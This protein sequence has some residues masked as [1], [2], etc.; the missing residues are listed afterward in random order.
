MRVDYV[1]VDETPLLTPAGKPAGGALLW[2]DRVRVLDES[3]SLAR[4]RT[5]RSRTPCHV[6]KA[7][8]GGRSLLEFYFID[9]GQGDGVLIRTPD[10]RH[11]LIDAGFPRAS[12]P[13]GKNA[14]DFVDWKF[15]RDYGQ[16]TIALDAVIASHNDEDHYGGLSDLVSPDPNDVAELDAAGVTVENFYH[17]GLSWWAGAERNLGPSVAT[18]QGEMWTRLLGNRASAAAALSGAGPQLQG[19]WARFIG[20]M[21]GAKTA[22]GGSTPFTRLSHDHGYLPGF[23][24]APG[25]AAIKVLAPVEFTVGGQPALRRLPAGDSQNTNGQSVLLRIDY[26]RARILL[27]GDLNAAAQGALLAD[28]A[29][30]SQELECDVAKACHHGSDDVSYRFLQAL[31]PA[32]TVISS[33]DNE[34]HDHPRP[35]IVGASA[36]TGYLE[37]QND[38]IVSP[39]IYSTELAR[40]LKLKRADSLQ[41]PLKTGETL[42]VTGKSLART[43]A[44]FDEGGTPPKV[45]RRGLDRTRLVTD[46]IYGLVNVRTDG[47][48]ILCATMGEKDRA[49]EIKKL[50]SRF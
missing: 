5:G 31:R 45:T 9:V 25:A 13:A 35:S 39:L 33:G 23:A 21:L 10:H 4:I 41:V 38:R 14:A 44:W 34:S 3:G 2:G 16:K 46:L 26:G 20:R 22:A 6:R 47:E 43:E 30:L 1:S 7:A 18:D 32:V 24:P 36:T 29:G 17:A 11:V 49:W 50:R 48:T 42:A 8:L 15:V 12:Q 40:S 19:R 37:I 27:T 28:Y